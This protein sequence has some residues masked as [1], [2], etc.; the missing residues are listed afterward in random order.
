MKTILITGGAGF[1][2]SMLCTELVKK[3]YNII[4]LDKLEYN[5][6]SLNH[7]MKYENLSFHKLNILN[8]KKLLKFI[9]KADIIIPL[10]ALVGA[11]LCEKN[12]KLAIQTN[13]KIIEYMVKNLKKKQRVIY[14][15]TNSGYG[16]GAKNKFCDEN[17]PL[18]PVS[19]YG[20]T[21]NKAEKII[22]SHKNSICFRLATVFGFSYRMRT[23]LLVNNLVKESLIKKKLTLFEP[24]F[25]RNFI[26]I[27]D[28]VD[29]IIFA[30]S[31]FN[32]LKKGEV[33]NLGLSSANFTKLQLAKKINKYIPI[34][35]SIDKKR[36]D[37]D[38]RDYFVS[39][40]KIEKKGFKCKHSL[41]KGIQELKK[42]YQI[43]MYDEI[44]NNY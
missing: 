6:N 20:V 11:P 16:I 21:K 25:R 44:K 42:I 19:L 35:I 9:K 43:N 34:K 32:K 5:K 39:N 29:A 30:I 33:Y 36:K 4:V 23:D 10:A 31:N 27:S 18:N 37:P 12:Q 28:V 40:D 38:Q 17:S 3:N 1:I 14:P 26:H 8:K 13:E 24:H 7:L 22:R 41:D 2:G 15:T